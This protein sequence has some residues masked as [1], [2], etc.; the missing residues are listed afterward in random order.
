MAVARNTG[1]PTVA[2]TAAAERATERVCYRYRLGGRGLRC[3]QRL[4]RR[5][6]HRRRL[7]GRRT[8]AAA[9]AG[10]SE[11][12]AVTAAAPTVSGRWPRC[13]PG[14]A[15]VEAAARSPRVKSRRPRH[16][17]GCCGAAG[18]QRGCGATRTAG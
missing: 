3:L 6:R 1:R 2:G 18:G 16:C 7:G 11:A 9:T 13:R 4:G 17:C 15:A 10:P 8:R 14:A 5:R 12:A